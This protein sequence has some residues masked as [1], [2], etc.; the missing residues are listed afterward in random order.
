MSTPCDECEA[1]GH[2]PAEPTGPPS[3]VAAIVGEALGREEELEGRPF[4]GRAGSL[5]RRAL[6]EAGIQPQECHFNNAVMFRPPG[7]RNPRKRE[8]TACAPR[9]R[10]QL[11]AAKPQCII[12]LGNYGMQAVTGDPPKGITKLRG[13]W[14]EMELGGQPVPVLL[15]LHP[16]YILRVPD[17]YDD[18]L[19]DLRSAR[20]GDAPDTIDPPYADYYIVS[21][22]PRF[23]EL[24][25]RL[26][27]VE[28]M[29]VDLET[30]GLYPQSEQ[31]A[32]LSIS[33]SW[34]AGTAVAVDWLRLVEGNP[35]N[36][37]RMKEAL[38][39]IRLAYHN[40]QFDEPWL[41]SRGIVAPTSM[42]T[43]LAHYCTDERQGTHA[44]KVLAKRLYQAPDYEDDLKLLLRDRG[45]LAK[46]IQPD[47]QPI[48]D[49]L[50]DYWERHGKKEK[51]AK[52]ED[53][54]KIPLAMDEATW[55]DDE[56]R[57]AVLVYNAA[58]ADYTLRLA[59]DM[60][61]EMRNQG[62]RHVHDRVMLP[63]I[64]HFQ[65]LERV[66]IRIDT[67]HQDSLGRAWAEEC[68]E[69]EAEIRAFPGAGDI[70][71][72]S[73]QQMERYLYDTLGLEPMPGEGE[74]LTLA[75]VMDAIGGV[76]DP[77]P[78]AREYWST[79]SS[80]V[81][82]NM[83]R[84]STNTYTLWYLAHQ[85]PFPR[86]MTQYRKLRTNL[87]TYYFSWRR[88]MW[89]DRIHPQHRIHGTR[90]GRGSYTDPNCH[91]I[92]RRKDIKNMLMADP[93]YVL[94]YLDFSQAEVRMLAHMS[95]DGGL[96]R[97]CDL[98]IHNETM[99]LLFSLTDEQAAALAPERREYFRRA[100]KTIVFGII[101]GRGAKSLAP[102]LGM[103]I[104]ETA[105]YRERFLR[106]IPRGTRWME[107]QKRQ[108][109]TRGYSETLQGFRRRYHLGMARR[110]RKYR[111][112]VE[113]QSVNQP[114]QGSVSMMTT[115]TAIRTH[116]RIDSWGVESRPF[117]HTHDGFGVFVPED[118]ADRA[119][120]AMIE[121]AHDVPFETDVRFAIE[122][123]RGQRWGD[124]EEV[125]SG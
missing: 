74:I 27:T 98:D 70:N 89:G 33:M 99:K 41:L 15:T 78:E 17:A 67:E 13:R 54:R 105:A 103:G 92:S 38:E 32:I 1:R 107:F 62:V 3:P 53:D 35:H 121:I 76:D 25:R 82:S 87:K 19:K 116:D 42:D 117:L 88:A 119:Q 56:S 64:R 65:R 106:G 125:Y 85:H 108:A 66:G 7:D 83:K 90:T 72:D 109:L 93:G 37:Q 63:A 29:S 59:H 28:L 77:I 95:G 43:M 11:E 115:E 45:T 102:Q 84:R 86:K 118:V 73:W 124:A 68:D 57:Q 79:E 21:E 55:A 51:A 26:E 12:A 6:V 16:A 91:G 4:V 112:D 2:C 104:E 97:M 122:V 123:S 100:A 14:T 71:L 101:Y 113:R 10:R 48:P 50:M 114:I 94:L 49:D 52:T 96:R 69:V 31:A 60:A 8:I 18:F 110:D 44:L 120:E 39:R 36:F 9:L 75:E 22:Q 61:R 46:P 58:D 47:H 40:A 81:F 111:G 20:T 34:R 23:D 80:A 5:L 30:I 24:M